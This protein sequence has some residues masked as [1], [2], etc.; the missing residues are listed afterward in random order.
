MITSGTMPPSQ[1][2]A[3]VLI[4]EDAEARTENTLAKLSKEGG[5]PLE[6]ERVHTLSE[7]RQALARRQDWHLVISDARLPG[8][9]AFQA[10]AVTQE[11]APR[12]PF[13][14]L[15]HDRPEVAIAEVVQQC[16]AHRAEPP[17][18][19]PEPGASSAQL[20]DFARRLLEAQEAERR[21]IARELHDEFGQLLTAVILNLET[22]QRR[23]GKASTSA[24]AEAIALVSRA[25]HQVRN[26]SIELW[27]TVLDD[28]GLP[29]ALRWLVDNQ[30]GPAGIDIQLDIDPLPRLERSVEVTCFRV[31]QEALTNVVRH[32]AARKATIELRVSAVTM[33]LLVRDDGSGFDLDAVRRRAA[34]GGPPSFGLFG[35]QERVLM[36]GGR[37]QT[38]SSPGRGTVVKAVFPLTP[39]L[40]T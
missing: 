20:F 4:I 7:L 34:H 39:E 18:P 3:S 35:M 5:V 11:I 30:A 38:E 8:A 9:V 31:V 2:M 13:V 40:T 12:L 17:A 15:A 28:L 36:A 25:I 6:W 27:P 1:P 21:H 22:A 10:L 29:A 33:T 32:A 16:V 14:V 24:M 23:R 19:K 26:F 37:F